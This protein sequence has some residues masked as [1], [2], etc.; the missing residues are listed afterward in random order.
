[1][2]KTKNTPK[3]CKRRLK[4]I[5]RRIDVLGSEETVSQFHPWLI[6]KPNVPLETSS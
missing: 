3:E 6:Y 1:M 5:E 2:E 4:E